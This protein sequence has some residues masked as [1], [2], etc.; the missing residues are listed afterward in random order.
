LRRLHVDLTFTGL[1]RYPPV[2]RTGGGCLDAARYPHGDPPSEEAIVSEATIQ[3]C[4]V[5]AGPVFSAS[6]TESGSPESGV[7][8]AE[9]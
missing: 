2:G 8:R 1:T 6:I 3:K 7:P 4:A 5:F 9:W